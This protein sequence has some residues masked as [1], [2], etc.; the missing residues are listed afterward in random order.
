[1]SIERI[2]SK[3]QARAVIAM[4]REREQIMRVANEQIGEI[5]AALDAQAE[6]MRA[7]FGLPEGRYV[8][9]GN[10]EGIKLEMKTETA[11]SSEVAG[12]GDEH[13]EPERTRGEEIA[14]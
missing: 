2:L 3:T 11:E 7:H 12:I 8:F 4:V 14:S 13:R 5:N 6:M 1:M 9:S 10:P